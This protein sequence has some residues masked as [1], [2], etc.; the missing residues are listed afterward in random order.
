MVSSRSATVGTM[1]TLV[2]APRAAR[3]RHVVNPREKLKVLK[4]NL[5]RLDAELVQQLA[6]AGALGTHVVLGVELLRAG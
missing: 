6:L 1:R 4:R 3:R 5:L 2:L